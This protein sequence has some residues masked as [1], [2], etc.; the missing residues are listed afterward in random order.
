M[1]Y[2]NYTQHLKKIFQES[3]DKRNISK[4]IHGFDG[5]SNQYRDRKQLIQEQRLF[6]GSS[7]LN[8]KPLT[9]LLKPEVLFG[10]KLGLHPDFKHLKGTDETENHYI[11]SAFIDIHGSTNLFKRYDAED[12]YRITNTIQSAA[13]H[14]CLTLGGHIQR[15]Q[16][17]GV[18]VYFGGKSTDRKRAVELSLIATS[19]FSYFIQNDLKEIFLEEGIED[20]YTR[21]GIDFGDD[22]DVLWANF[23]LMEVSELTTLSLHTSLASKMQSNAKRNG[24]IVGQFVKD[25]LNGNDGLFSIISEDL[26]YIFKNHEDNF[27]YT[28]YQFDWKGYLKSLPFVKEDSAGKLSLLDLP[29]NELDRIQ[30]LRSNSTLL[31]TGNAFLDKQGNITSNSG[32]KHEPHRFHYGK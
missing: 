22:K 15:L 2:N 27:F 4:G 10:A 6:S 1:I 17:D 32:V 21:I 25:R 8:T 12:I 16:G 3:A 14:T 5:L 13:I 31:S 18:F 11:V 24:I 9:T 28:Q 30:R 7:H 19:M 23:G 26:R 29:Q 20:I